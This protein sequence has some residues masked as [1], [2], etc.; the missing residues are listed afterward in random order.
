MKVVICYNY[1]VGRLQGKC[2]IN[3]AGGSFYSVFHPN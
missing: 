3:E 1:H 2:R